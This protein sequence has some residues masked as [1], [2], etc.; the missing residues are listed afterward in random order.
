MNRSAE[1]TEQKE[2]G[3]ENVCGGFQS[4]FERTETIEE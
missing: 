2:S 3:T 4:Y 1:C